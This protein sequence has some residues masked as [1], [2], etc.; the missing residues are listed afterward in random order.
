MDDEQK[1]ANCQTNSRARRIDRVLDELKAWR[2]AASIDRDRSVNRI[3]KHWFFVQ[4]RGLCHGSLRGNESKPIIIV[5]C[6]ILASASECRVIPLRKQVAA[7]IRGFTFPTGGRREILYNLEK[8]NSVRYKVT[9]QKYRKP[10]A[11]FFQFNLRIFDTICHALDF[12]I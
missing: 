3:W 5:N 6:L 12:E 10:S 4:V 7:G 9:L 11:S 2:P 8:C 1:C